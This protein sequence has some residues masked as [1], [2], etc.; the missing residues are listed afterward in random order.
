MVFI[1]YWCLVTQDTIS[2]LIAR[3]VLFMHNVAELYIIYHF[4]TA[5]GFPAKNKEG[6]SRA[7]YTMNVHMYTHFHSC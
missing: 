7:K 2:E 5:R 1:T 3:I 4:Y 6:N